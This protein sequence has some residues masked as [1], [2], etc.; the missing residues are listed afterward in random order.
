M[1]KV[2]EGVLWMGGLAE[3]MTEKFLRDGFSSLGESDVESVEIVKNKFT[4]KPAGYG[5]VYF[6][7]DASALMAM[8]KLNGKTI[9]NSQPPIRFQLNHSSAQ[10]SGNNPFSDREFSIWVTDLPDNCTDEKLMRTFATR[11]DSIK[12][13]RVQTDSSHG[14]K[15]YGFVRF[16]DQHE[17]RDALIHMNGFRGMGDKP[18]KVSMAIPKKKPGKEEEIGS[19]GGAGQYSYYY[20]SYWAD[21][22]A[23]GNYASLAGGHGGGGPGHS[24]GKHFIATARNNAGN[25][26]TYHEPHNDD[27]LEEEEDEERI[28][29][30]DTPVNVDAMNKEF[31]DRSVEAWEGIERDRWLYSFDTEDSIIPNF[32][33]PFGYKQ[34]RKDYEDELFNDL[35]NVDG[36]VNEDFDD[37]KLVGSVN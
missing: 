31:M 26:D 13:A 32:D 17:Q 9:P 25:A 16:T 36:E 4:G 8:H 37:I 14:K 12:T 11:F 24:E 19:R 23:W 28:I 29:E 10:A 27:W 15:P 33:K 5:F 20:E 21:R 2:K 30:W 35:G 1:P 22:A 34:K 6:D 7:T 18:I 3:Y